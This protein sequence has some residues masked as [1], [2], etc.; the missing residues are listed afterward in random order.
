MH[1]SSTEA[2]TTVTPNMNKLFLW[3]EENVLLI[4]P[5]GPFMTDTTISVRIA[6]N[7]LD[8]DGIALGKEYSMWFRTAPFAVSYVSPQNAQLFVNPTQQIT[9]TFNSYVKLNSVQS[10]IQISPSIPGSF[11]YS[12]SGS[13]EYPQIV[14]FTPSSG[15]ATNTKYTVTVSTNVR[16]LFD[17][18]L[19]TPYVFSFVTRP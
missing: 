7:A 18:K 8:K 9:I 6:A 13:Y 11:S 10:G 5:G 4:Y 16:D 19:K 17:S 14:I 15:M 1:A 3:P 2:A 12:N